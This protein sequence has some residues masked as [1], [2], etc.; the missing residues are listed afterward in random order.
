[1]EISRR[2]HFFVTFERKVDVLLL[3]LVAD[4]KDAWLQ[5]GDA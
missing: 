2:F 1:M 5:G 4:T 3:H